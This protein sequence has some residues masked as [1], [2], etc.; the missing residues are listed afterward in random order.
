MKTIYF[1]NAYHLGLSSWPPGSHEPTG[2]PGSPGSPQPIK[3]QCSP[4]QS[5]PV[6]SSTVQYSPV[7]P[8]T[9]QHSP[10]QPSTAQYSTVQSTTAHHH[11]CRWKYTTMYTSLDC[12]D[13]LLHRSTLVLFQ[14]IPIYWYLPD[15]RKV[16]G[17]SSKGCSLNG[18]AVVL[19][20]GYE[21]FA[22]G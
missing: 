17:S 15:S 18:S 12:P 20:D 13:S 14:Y 2:P 16:L 3:S 10:A 8:N 21:H 22:G 11:Q 7:Q 19:F 6:E 5:S 1:L 9:A 4:A